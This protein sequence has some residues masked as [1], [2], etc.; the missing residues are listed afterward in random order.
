MCTLAVLLQA[1][2]RYPLI[3]AANRDEDR[4]RPASGP[5]LWPGSPAFVAGR[6]ER[7]GGTWMGL[8]EQG[9]F[10]GLTNLWTGEPADPTRASRGAVVVELLR[11][12]SLEDARQRLLGRSAAATNPF[13]VVCADSAGRGW[14]ASTQE[15][16]RPREL[17]VGLFVLGNL[18]AGDPGDAKLQRAAD[19]L[20]NPPLTGNDTPSRV[21]RLQSALGTH[22][23]DRGPR[24]SLCVHTD[25]NYGTVSSTILMTAPGGQEARMLHAAGPPCTAPFADCSHLLL[26]LSRRAQLKGALAAYGAADPQEQTHQRRMEELLQHGTDPFARDHYAPGHFTASAF[27]LSPDRRSLL[28]VHHAKLDRWLQPGGHVE[29]QD[30]TLLAAARRE[31]VEETDAHLAEPADQMGIFD[32]DVHVIPA[33][34]D[35]PAH[36]HFDVRYLLAA[37]DEHLQASPDVRDARWV[38]LDEVGRASADESVLRA[39]R[40]LRAAQR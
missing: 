17:G 34:G 4:T 24:E 25:G 39:V 18:A 1:P 30:A 7:A 28:L 27:V 13:L 40:K 2:G 20:R 38:P 16:L 15:G 23:G 36:E 22:H 26:Q 9:I 12:A 6:D 31:V 3:V 37:R 19:L 11:S 5:L 10:A 35:A 21:R 14:W 8:N 32:V 29:P 33:R